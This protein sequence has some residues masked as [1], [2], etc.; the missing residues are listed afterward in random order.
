[1]NRS[2]VKVARMAIVK[3]GT[4]RDD[5]ISRHVNGLK[6]DKTGSV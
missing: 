5:F 2:S 1:M 4:V 3:N 6:L